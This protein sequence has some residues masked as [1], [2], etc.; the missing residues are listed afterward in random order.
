MKD[1]E[2]EE[3]DNK[4]FSNGTKYPKMDEEKFTQL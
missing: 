4:G 3:T 1:K 2:N